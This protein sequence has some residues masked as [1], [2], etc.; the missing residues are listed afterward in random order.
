MV[1]KAETKEMQTRLGLL[2]KEA[3]WL[4]NA[5]RYQADLIVGFMDSVDPIPARINPPQPPPICVP[6]KV[7]WLTIERLREKLEQI[8]EVAAEFRRDLKKAVDE[9]EKK[10]IKSIS[11][12]PSQ[13]PDYPSTK[14]P[15][16]AFAEEAMSRR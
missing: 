16:R 11:F 15:K 2:W 1:M 5:H 3:R 12:R 14:E 9:A 7:C 13:L 10:G 4:E 8:E 6:P